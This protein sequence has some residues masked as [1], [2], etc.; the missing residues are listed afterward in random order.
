M[1]PSK[2]K[3]R[4][5]I[6]A[7]FIALSL[8]L[9]VIFYLEV[10]FPENVLGYFKKSYYGQFGPLAICVELLIGAYYLFIGHKKSNFALALFAFTAL[11]D[12]I[13]NLTG[14]F[15]S[16]VPP[17]AMVLFSICA[18]ISLWIAFSNAFNLGR[19]TLFWVVTSLVL[20]SAIEFYFNYF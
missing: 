17:Y 12:I 15:I 11:L 2:M 9:G 14:V 8:V 20:G 5:G 16:G 1:T 19:I 6:A 10:E 4:K 7:V 3:K 18:I 13:F